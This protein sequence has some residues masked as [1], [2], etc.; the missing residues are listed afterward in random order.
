MAIVILAYIYIAGEQSAH[1]YKKLICIQNFILV[2]MRI[3]I[4]DALILSRATRVRLKKV[5]EVDST[6][7]S[8]IVRMFRIHYRFVS[9]F[10]R[11]SI[12]TRS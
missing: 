3:E 11:M 9:G 1:L 4:S 10:A 6:Y 5:R 12:H 2:E 7:S 8:M